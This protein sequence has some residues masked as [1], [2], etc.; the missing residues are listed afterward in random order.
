[1]TDNFLQT[2]GSNAGPLL[3]FQSFSSI[4]ASKIRKDLPEKLP[5]NTE[6]KHGTPG[7]PAMA[8]DYP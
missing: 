8:Q 7:C 2:W 6:R 3:D 5:K 1:M 4:Q